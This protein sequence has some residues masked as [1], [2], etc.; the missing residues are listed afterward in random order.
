MRNNISKD[1]VQIAFGSIYRQW[2]AS[3]D[4]ADIEEVID[5]AGHL[6]RAVKSV[7]LAAEPLMLGVHWLQPVM[8]GV[9]NRVAIAVQN[10]DGSPAN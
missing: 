5:D 6:E 4:T 7:P 8:L 10:A 1:L 9:L 2:Q 3:L